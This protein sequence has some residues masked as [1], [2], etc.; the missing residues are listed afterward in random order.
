MREIIISDL[1]K[2]IDV[3]HNGL[4]F[5]LSAEIENYLTI[6]FA[7]YREIPLEHLEL[8]DAT[9]NYKYDTRIKNTELEFKTQS[10]KFLRIE[11]SKTDSKKKGG[12]KDS[13][14]DYYVFLNPGKSQH[15]GVWKLFLKVR[16]IKTDVLRDLINNK[17]ELF[18]KVNSI[19][20]ADCVEVDPKALEK[21]LIWVGNIDLINIES[22]ETMSFNLESLRLNKYLKVIVIN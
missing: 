12:L 6:S 3:E 20:E 1:H 15:Y 19:T 7:K 16:I 8:S 10:S 14:A 13:T 4:G 22:R 11:K 9:Y 2:K 5:K 21:Y 17:P 18:S